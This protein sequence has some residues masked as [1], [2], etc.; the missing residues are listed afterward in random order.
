MKRLVEPCKGSLIANKVLRDLYSVLY[1]SSPKSVFFSASNQPIQ[2]TK[3]P[4]SVKRSVIVVKKKKIPDKHC[5]N[6]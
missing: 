2:V 1:S 4:N 3:E 5:T 6:T